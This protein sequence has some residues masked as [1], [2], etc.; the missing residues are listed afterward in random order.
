MYPPPDPAQLAAFQAWQQQQQQ[1]LQSQFR[2]APLPAA[3]Q[4]TYA[5]PPQPLTLPPVYMP[6]P[7]PR[8]RRQRVA[9]PDPEP[10][11][12]PAGSLWVI[13]GCLLLG[14]AGGAACER[15]FRP[16]VAVAAPVVPSAEPCP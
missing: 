15:H 3:P 14:A 7:L 8:P 4:P 5:L 16:S 10:V 13:L 12:S 11:E 9:A 2:M 1:Q 6:P